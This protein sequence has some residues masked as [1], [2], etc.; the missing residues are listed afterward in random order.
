MELNQELTMEAT[1]NNVESG[2]R[3]ASRDAGRPAAA[4]AIIAEALWLEENATTQASEVG[5]SIDDIMG[6]VMA[7]TL[8]G[9]TAATWGQFMRRRH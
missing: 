2:S 7:F 8:K 1:K 6:G 3:D 4:I 5:F 9:A